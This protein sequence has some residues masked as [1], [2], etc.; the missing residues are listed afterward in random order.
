MPAGFDTR[1]SGEIDLHLGGLI[2]GSYACSEHCLCYL[3]SYQDL[4]FQ[5]K[6]FSFLPASSSGKNVS[7][8]LVVSGR[9]ANQSI[10]YVGDQAPL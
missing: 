9:H 6:A 3:T 5:S 10:A 4:H 8:L 7:Q 2:F 1:L